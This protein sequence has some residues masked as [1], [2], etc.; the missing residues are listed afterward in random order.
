MLLAIAVALVIDG[1]ELAAFGVSA[2]MLAPLLVA[3]KVTPAGVMFAAMMAA[4]APVLMA[5]A[6]GVGCWWQHGSW[7]RRSPT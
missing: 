7:P 3:G 6:D 2:A 5:G 1:E 4:T